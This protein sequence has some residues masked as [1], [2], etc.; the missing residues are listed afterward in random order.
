MIVRLQVNCEA[1][2]VLTWNMIEVDFGDAFP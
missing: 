2:L 1:E